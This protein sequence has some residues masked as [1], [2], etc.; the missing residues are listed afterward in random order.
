[1]QVFTNT[2]IKV[3]LRGGRCDK[4]A[5]MTGT[6]NSYGGFNGFAYQKM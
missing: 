6:Y 1:M 2:M 5:E 3:W 4:C